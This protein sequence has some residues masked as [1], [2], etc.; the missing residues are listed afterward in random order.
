[1]ATYYIRFDTYW[2][3]SADRFCGPF[4]SREEAEA[5]IK[6]AQNAPNSMVTRWGQSPVDVKNAVRV[7]EIVTKTQAGRGLNPGLTFDRLPLNLDEL[8]D[9]EQYMMEY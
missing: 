9:E 3:N 1:M 6:R 5:E 2:Q 8:A 7:L 4:N